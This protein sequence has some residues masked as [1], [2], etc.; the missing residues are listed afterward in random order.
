M[1]KPNIEI[2]E[3]SPISVRCNQP[4]TITICVIAR[5]LGK[6]DV[7]VRIP[8]ALPCHFIGSGGEHQQICKTYEAQ[9]PRDKICIDFEELLIDCSE[10]DRYRTRLTAVA[11][12]SDGE[13]RITWRKLIINCD[14]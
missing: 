7:Y 14:V 1:A 6:C 12:N 13:T 10:N 3:S 5:S 4:F 9:K 11:T 8:D 2:L